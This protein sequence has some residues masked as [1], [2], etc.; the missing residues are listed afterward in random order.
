[1]IETKNTTQVNVT[2]Q[3]NNLDLAIQ[4]K[5]LY[6]LMAINESIEKYQTSKNTNED[7]SHKSSCIDFQQLPYRHINN[8]IFPNG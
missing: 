8:C 6:E 3:F 4:K 1:M 2:K 5:G 7:M